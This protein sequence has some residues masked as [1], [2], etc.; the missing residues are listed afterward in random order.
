VPASA[1]SAHDVL[2]AAMSAYARLHTVALDESLASAPTGGIRTSFVFVAPDRLRYAIKGGS[3][4]IVIGTRRWDRPTG[5]APWTSSPQARTTVMQLLWERAIDAHL[6]APH[7]VTFFDQATHAW[8][9]VVVDPRTSLPKTVY[10]TG[11]SHFMVD[12]YSRYNAPATIAPPTTR[13]S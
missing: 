11:T 8:F 1:P 13:S 2:V 10:M 4:A 3:Q 12:R 9:R 5:D 7:T 6:V